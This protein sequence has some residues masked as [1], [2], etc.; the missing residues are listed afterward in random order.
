MIVSS[1]DLP[2]GHHIEADVIIVGAGAAGITLALELAGTGLRVVIFEAGTY[3]ID[4]LTQQLYTGETR[5]FST[6]PLDVSRLRMFGGTTNHWSGLCLELDEID[7]EPR[8]GVPHT[9]WPIA[10]TE[11]EPYWKRAYPYVEI[12]PDAPNDVDRVVEV[13]GAPKLGFDPAKWDHVVMNESPPTIFGNRYEAELEQAPNVDI[14][15]DANVL[16]I[17]VSEDAGTV[18][19]LRLACIDGPRFTASAR[20]YVLAAG[21]IEIP[22]LLLLSNSVQSD[23]LGNGNDL[24]GRFFMD[25]NTMRPTVMALVPDSAPDLSLYTGSHWD[26]Q[27]AA[28]IM[29]RG[30]PDRIRRE[31][32]GN[33]RAHF[34]ETDR[35]T[36]GASAAKRM[37]DAFSAGQIPEH[38]GR[39]L[40]DAATDLDGITDRLLRRLLRSDDGP[41]GRRWIEVWVGFEQFPNRDSRIMLSEEL[42]LF[43][44]N[45]VICD[46]RL[47][48]TELR[49]AHRAAELVAE[50]IGRLGIGRSWSALLSTPDEWPRTQ[51]GKHH[52]G[53]TRMSD[54]PATG[55]VNTD[56]RM[57]SVDNLYVASSS[58]FPTEGQ[59][60]P[61][62]TIVALS[63]R[64][65][66]KLKSVLDI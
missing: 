26:G 50:E 14:Y 8:E 11:L 17:E 54:S 31:R 62:L 40:Y 44:Q 63:I 25:H 36:P 47:G 27:Y 56:C 24:V 43:G 10:R 60:A 42:D 15:L 19:G 37:L 9:G 61:T 21:G 5:G 52:V 49:T 38:L 13:S 46:W 32:L 59:A 65:A 45:K 33:F 55:V 57:H 53:T 3:G 22:R 2:D 29:L 64:L 23:G 7:F 51:P 41:L 30:A 58:V 28:R 6:V 4:D 66:D 34:F 12:H 39:H 48:E 20:A 1:T 35:L 16:E 18:T